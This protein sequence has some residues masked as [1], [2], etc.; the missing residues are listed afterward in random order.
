MLSV[1]SLHKTESQ[2]NPN[3]PFTQIDNKYKRNLQ[4]SEFEI[5]LDHL[6]DELYKHS[7]QFTS[8]PKIF[9]QS[10]NNEFVLKSI[11]ETKKNIVEHAIKDQKTIRTSNDITKD[12]FQ[13]I[14]FVH[15]AE[16][17]KEVLFFQMWFH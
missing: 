7:K 12:H 11:I 4:Q 15:K 2:G 1:I 3:F 10:W 14:E 6:F 5:I 8:A 13:V 16:E 9:S 17:M